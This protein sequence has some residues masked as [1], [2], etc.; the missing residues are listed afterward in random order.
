MFCMLGH[1]L[2][3]TKAYCVSNSGAELLL[4]LTALDHSKDAKD[5]LQQDGDDGD[6]D[7]DEEEEEEDDEDAAAA[8]DDDD[9]DDADDDAAAADDDDDD[10]DAD[11]DADDDAAA[12]DDDGDGDADDDA[13]ADDGDGD[14]DDYDD[15]HDD[16][17]QLKLIG[18]QDSAFSHLIPIDDLLPCNWTWNMRHR[19]IWKSV[20]CAELMKTELTSMVKILQ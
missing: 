2:D 20:T 1:L 14:G 13:A 6:D 7:D 4:R 5:V 9:D 17:V 12:D 18:I 11:A 8:A 16:D 19:K 3:T 15:H 10:D